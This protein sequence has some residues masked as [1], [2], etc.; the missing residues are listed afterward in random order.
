LNRRVTE[1]SRVTLGKAKTVE[2]MDYF[3]E[4][5]DLCSPVPDRESLIIDNTRLSAAETAAQIIEYFNLAKPGEL[6]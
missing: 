6:S 4:T 3:H 5:Y 2:M 1:E